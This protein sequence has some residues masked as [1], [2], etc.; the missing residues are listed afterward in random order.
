MRGEAIRRLLGLEER[1]D[2]LLEFDVEDT[3]V[4][5]GVTFC[6]GAL[7]ARDGER[8]PAVVLLPEKQSPRAPG[9]WFHHQHASRWHLGKSEVAG[10]AGDPLQSFGPSLARSGMVVLTIDSVGFEDRRTR[11]TGTEPHE[12]DGA[13]WG[14]Q[15]THRLVMGDTL[16][17]KVLAD[18]EDALVALRSLDGVDPARV[19]V[20]G[21]S[22]GGNVAIFQA[23]IDQRVAF[24]C[25]SGAAGTYREKIARD[26]GIDLFLTVPGIA[27]H[28][29]IDDVL[30]AV[31]PRP[32][33]V[34]AGEDD[35]YAADADQIVASV[36]T[37][38]GEH[39]APGAFRGSIYPGGHPLTQE[40]HDAIID[41][42]LATA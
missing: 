28:L 1:V 18:A 15:L 24:A 35:E 31:A 17:R 3:E 36:G 13:Q 21:H 23:A 7:V 5:A 25:V 2:G 12:D 32:L 4:R 14:R 22:Y 34:L 19:G 11:C 27:R 8:I 20:A 42:I 41:W 30:A 33:F 26:I 9:V 10:W 40:R 16:A 29:D 39:G 37:A 6:R 38:Y